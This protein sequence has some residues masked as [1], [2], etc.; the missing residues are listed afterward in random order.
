MK[1]YILACLLLAFPASVFG[2]AVTGPIQAA[3]PPPEQAAPAQMRLSPEQ[4]FAAVLVA[5]EK[6]DASAMLNL[7]GFY[8]Q[9]FGIS[10]DFTRA[11]GWYQKAADAGL[12]EGLYNVGI[13]HEI[14]MGTA[15]DPAKA[16]GFY[17]KAADKGLAMA[18][19]KLYAVYARGQGTPPDNDQAFTHLLK[20]ADA[21]FIP[22]QGEAAKVYLNG[23]LGQPK[24]PEKALAYVSRAA[25]RGDPQAAYDLALMHRDG[26]GTKADRGA[27]LRWAFILKKRKI[28]GLDPLVNEL[29]KGLP[30]PQ[31][32]S[33]EAK[34]DA[35]V[36][37]FG[38]RAQAPE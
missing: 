5:A 14:G 4:Q 31:I 35:W 36:K 38:R 2:G 24:N 29:K 33:A 15:G 20:A 9:G 25:E 7:G 10:R 32:A 6:G 18:H 3:P 1:K 8:E 17:Q 28:D 19:F 30:Q 12:P 11:L 27:A 34:A 22:A 37:N 26:V 13:A 23:L 16:L 21:G